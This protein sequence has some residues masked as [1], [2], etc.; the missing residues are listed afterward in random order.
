MAANQYD[1]N[2]T[3]VYYYPWATDNV[4]AN[5]IVTCAPPSGSLPAGRH[6]DGLVLGHGQLGQHG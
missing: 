5:P 4:D 2:G 3:Y 1:T 6:D